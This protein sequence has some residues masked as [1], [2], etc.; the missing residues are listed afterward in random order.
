MIGIGVDGIAVAGSNGEFPLLS[1]EE[2][3]RL[4][5][6]A[7]EQNKGRVSLIAGTGTVATREVIELNKEAH[8]LGM[9]ASMIITPYYITPTN[10]EL[11]GHYKAISDA[12]DLPIYV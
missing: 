5:K 1:K 12:V 7:V 8:Q 3:K 9:T 10:K 11:I 2:T 4:F 6:L